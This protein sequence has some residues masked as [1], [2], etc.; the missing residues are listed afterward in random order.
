MIPQ[1][2]KLAQELLHA[3]RELTAEIRQLRQEGTPPNSIRGI[4]TDDRR[5]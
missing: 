3:V 5:G 4:W 2:L 1:A